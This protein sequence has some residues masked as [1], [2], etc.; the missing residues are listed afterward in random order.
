MPETNQNQ[1]P[2]EKPEAP[3]AP[4][5]LQEAP[6]AAPAP[7]PEKLQEYSK[8][9]KENGQKTARAAQERLNKLAQVTPS[10]E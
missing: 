7:T 10:K 4:E 6:S 1:Q 8:T 3:A 5:Q 2:Q 9:I